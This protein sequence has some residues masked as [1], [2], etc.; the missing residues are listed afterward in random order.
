MPVSKPSLTGRISVAALVAA[1]ALGPVA[2]P[3][4]PAFASAGPAS[5]ADLSA[6]LIDSVVNISTT[7]TVGGN[8]SDGDAA[9]QMPQLPPGTPFEEFFNEFFKNRKN[10]E[11]R[12]QKTSSLGSGFVIDPSGIIVTNNHVIEGADDIEVNFNDGSKL[13]ATLVGR[14]KKVDIAVLKVSPP[15]PLKSVNFGDSDRIRVGDWALAI[16]NPFGL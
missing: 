15:K 11:Q 7:Q 8:S 14:D 4:A 9:P 16:G 13:K 10:G 3:A 1:L 6:Q 12:P 5:V 2:L